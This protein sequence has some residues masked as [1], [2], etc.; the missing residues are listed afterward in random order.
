[1]S[2]GE[3]VQAMRA[4]AQEALPQGAQTIEERECQAATN[5]IC[6]LVGKL[7]P[8]HTQSL[9]ELIFRLTVSLHRAKEAID[10]TATRELLESLSDQFH[11][12]GRTSEASTSP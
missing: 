2:W 10:N 3:H 1:M 4:E 12:A 6:D 7:D 11:E 5:I 8:A 9:P